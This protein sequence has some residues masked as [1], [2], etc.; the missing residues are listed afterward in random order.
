MPRRTD[1]TCRAQTVHVAL[2]VKLRFYCK[3]AFRAVCK[4]S[5]CVEIP[6]SLCCLSNCIFKAGVTHTIPLAA[7]AAAA[8]QDADLILIEYSVNGC[9]GSLFCH[10]FAAPRVGCAGVHTAVSVLGDCCS[11]AALLRASALPAC[12]M[13]SCQTRTDML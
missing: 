11:V 2:P 3:H 5:M 10:S 4:G 1:V 7:A 8:A 6:I 13:T 12:C 9:V